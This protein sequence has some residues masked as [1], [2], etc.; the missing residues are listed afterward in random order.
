MV[1]QPS[2][3]KKTFKIVCCIICHIVFQTSESAVLSRCSSI[4][5]FNFQVPVFAIQEQIKPD[6]ILN[7]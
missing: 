7:S 1:H 4:L 3:K 5:T 2:N 6:L